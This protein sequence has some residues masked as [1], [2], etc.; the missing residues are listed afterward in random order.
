VLPARYRPP[1]GADWVRVPERPAAVVTGGLAAGR[2]LWE[3]LCAI[4]LSCEQSRVVITRAA[5]EGGASRR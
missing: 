1:L 5:A 2:F 3:V 4:E